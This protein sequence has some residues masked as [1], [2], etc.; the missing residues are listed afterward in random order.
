MTA[1][2]TALQGLARPLKRWCCVRRGRACS[3]D[4]SVCSISVRWPSTRA[5]E[6]PIPRLSSCANT[7]TNAISVAQADASPRAA[8]A[9]RSASSMRRHA[10]RSSNS[11]AARSGASEADEFRGR[12]AGGGRAR[13]FSASAEKQA[14]STCAG[15]PRS[16]HPPG[17]APAAAL[18]PH[19][20]SDAR[21]RAARL[22]APERPATAAGAGGRAA[23]TSGSSSHACTE[24]PDSAPA[25]CPISTG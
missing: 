7:G 19:R 10:V 16:C 8:T 4:M 14:R 2:I 13:C 5:G 20:T 17:T 6:N 15:R 25:A 1:P 22:H 24:R 3:S 23:S 12:S 9:A 21:A 11:A 18:R